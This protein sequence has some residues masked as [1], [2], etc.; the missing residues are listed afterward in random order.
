VPSTPAQPTHVATVSTIGEAMVVLLP[1]GQRPL[2][3]TRRFDTAIG[4][5]EFNVASSLARLGAPAHWLSRLGDDGFGEYILEVAREAGVAVDAVEIDAARSTGIYVKETVTDADGSRSPRMHYYRTGSAASVITS[6]YFDRAESRAVFAASAIV[7]TSG[8]TPAL[9]DDT[10]EA[11]RDLRAHL[12][13]QSS[14]SVDL[15]YRPR[16]WTDQSTDPLLRLIGQADL[17]FLG[18]DESEAFFGHADA[19]RL[20]ADYPRLTRIVFKND[21]TSAI[22]VHRDG[23]THEV[24]CLTVDVVET[25]GAGDAFAAGYLYGVAAGLDDVAATR[26]GH[27]TAASTLICHGDRPDHVPAPHELRTVIA[28]SD[29]EWAGWRVSADR[30]FPWAAGG[31]GEADGSVRGSND[32]AAGRGTIAVEQRTMGA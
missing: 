2:V 4:G 6:G 13:P 27:A 5:A 1:E 9:S 19:A 16:L 11:V 21:A 30:P 23:P 20:F 14:L 17:L 26:I 7:H 29:D 25:V 12:A 10:A 28:A 8:I 22:T 3:E 15:N 32:G 31:A 24:P 18:V